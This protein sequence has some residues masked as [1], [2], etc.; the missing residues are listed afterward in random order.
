[1]SGTLCGLGSVCELA[2]E[3]SWVIVFSHSEQQ[4]LMGKGHPDLKRPKRLLRK[5]ERKQRKG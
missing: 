1:M 2:L 4:P 3:I 5:A